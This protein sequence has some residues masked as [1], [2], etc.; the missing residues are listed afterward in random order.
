MILVAIPSEGQ[1]SP[2]YR[3]LGNVVRVPAGKADK[4]ALQRARPCAVHLQPP[5]AA[6]RLVDHFDIPSAVELLVAGPGGSYQE[7]EGEVEF[8]HRFL[9]NVSHDALRLGVLRAVLLN[10]PGGC[11]AREIAAHFILK[12][13]CLAASPACLRFLPAD[14]FPPPN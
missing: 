8:A 14:S 1:L 3:H 12:S 11:S 6:A 7:K 13:A 10:G 5:G 2:G 9:L 4:P